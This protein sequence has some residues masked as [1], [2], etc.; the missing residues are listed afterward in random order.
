MRTSLIAA[1]RRGVFISEQSPQA[2]AQPVKTTP[3]LAQVTEQPHGVHS[4]HGHRAGL[5]HGDRPTKLL[6]LLSG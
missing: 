4:L 3:H 5:K 6:D 1:L 2:V